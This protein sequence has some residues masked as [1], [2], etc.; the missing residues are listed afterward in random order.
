[1]DIGHISG[2]VIPIHRE[3]VVEGIVEQI[4]GDIANQ[5]QLIKR[6]K[7]SV[8]GRIGNILRQVVLTLDPIQPL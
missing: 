4:P 8:L 3:H 6:V 7:R 1:M 5:Q 2:S